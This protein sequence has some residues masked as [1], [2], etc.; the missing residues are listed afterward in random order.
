[1]LKYNY[2]SSFSKR[3]GNTIDKLEKDAESKRDNIGKHQQQL[4]Q[5]MVKQAAKWG[6]PP[7]STKDK[8]HQH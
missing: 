1:M 7:S 3:H 4:Q 5:M 2:I 8:T 6:R